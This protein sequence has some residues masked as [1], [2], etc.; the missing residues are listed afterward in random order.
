MKQA[1]KDDDCGGGG[2]G[3]DD[4]GGELFPRRPTEISAYIKR[5]RRRRKPTAKMIPREMTLEERHEK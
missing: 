1:R 5:R 3:H 2:F 4:V